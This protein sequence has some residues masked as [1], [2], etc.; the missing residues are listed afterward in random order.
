MMFVGIVIILSACVV[1]A[2]RHFPDQTG[3]VLEQDTDTAIPDAIVVARWKGWISQLVDSQSVCYHVETSSTDAKGRYDIK[4][5]TKLSGKVHHESISYTVYKPG[6]RQTATKGNSHYLEKERGSVE[7]RLEYL[8][9]IAVTCGMK[10]EDQQK[11]LALYSAIYEEANRIAKTNQEKRKALYHLKR[12]E[13]IELGS[14]EA[15]R[16]FY[17]REREL[18]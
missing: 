9:S 11:L 13:W 6:Y 16:R 15:W 10:S 8:S 4:D 12:I 2:S 17:Q 1:G 3:T 5:W 18:Q 7:E 14:D